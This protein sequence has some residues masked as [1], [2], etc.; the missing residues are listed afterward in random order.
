MKYWVY[1]EK[2]INL[3]STSSAIKPVEISPHR[4]NYIPIAYKPTNKIYILYI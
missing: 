1:A 3:L 4:A 2:F